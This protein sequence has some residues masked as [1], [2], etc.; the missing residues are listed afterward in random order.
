VTARGKG[1]PS[2]TRRNQ[3]EATRGGLAVHV[4]GATAVFRVPGIYRPHLDAEPGDARRVRHAGVQVRPREARRSPGS[5]TGRNS[6]AVPTVSVDSD[7]TGALDLPALISSRSHF[8][9][10]FYRGFSQY[11]P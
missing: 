11:S 8:L 1:V 5:I 10:V 4:G 2:S 6:E 3:P 9:L 7:T